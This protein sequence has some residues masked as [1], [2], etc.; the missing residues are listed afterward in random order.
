MFNKKEIEYLNSIRDTLFHF[1]DINFD[2]YA[3]NYL[4]K[5]TL[6]ERS[7]LAI[8]MLDLETALDI[9]GL[10]S[11]VYLGIN[12]NIEMVRGICNVEGLYI[13]NGYLDE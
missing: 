13:R 5:L 2:Y 4:I 6:R 10:Y 11:N 9:Q 8:Y 12:G 1:K 7:S 3:I